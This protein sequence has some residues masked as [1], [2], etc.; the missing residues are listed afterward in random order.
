[1]RETAV[2]L[3]KPLG[4]H[5]N[6]AIALA[7]LVCFSAVVVFAAFAFADTKENEAAELLKKADDL[8]NKEE[9]KQSWDIYK[10]LLKDY[11]GTTAVKRAQG[12]IKKKI[13]TC[14]DK[15]GVVTDISKLFKGKAVLTKPSGADYLSLS[16]DFSDKE[17]LKDFKISAR[18]QSSVSV[19]DKKLQINCRKNNSIILPLKDTIFTRQLT[20]E[21]DFDVVSAAAEDWNVVG[22]A[23]FDDNNSTG[24]FFF[25]HY[26]LFQSG[27]YGN[28]IGL[29]AEKGGLSGLKIIS[30]QAKPVIEVGKPQH[31]KIESKDGYHTLTINGQASKT[32]NDN[33][34]TLGVIGIGCSDATV[35][36]SNLKIAGIL[37]PQWVKKTLSGQASVALAVDE[38]KQGLEDSLKARNEKC[39]QINTKDRNLLEP[40]P[41]EARKAYQNGVMLIDAYSRINKAAAAEIFKEFNRALECAPKFAL[42]YYYRAVCNYLL[43]N[44][45]AA[46][47][48]LSKAVE[49]SPDFYEAYKKRADI[50]VDMSKF[51]DA[52]KDYE[53]ALSIKNDYPY[54]LAGLGYLYFILGEEKKSTDCLSKALSL[55]PENPEAIEYN[56]FL[57][58]IIKGPPWKQTFTKSS[59]HYIVKTDTS[60]KKADTYADR[61]EKAYR[62][63]QSFFPVKEDSKQKKGTV[64][65]FDSQTSY[66]TYAFLTTESS[67][68]NTLGYYHPHYRQLLLFEPANQERET[69]GVLYHEAFHMFLHHQMG[70]GGKLPI[71]LNE[72]MAEF[73]RGTDFEQGTQVGLVLKDRLSELLDYIGSRGHY[74]F[75]DIMSQ[76]KREFYEEN[77]SVKYAQAW[78]MVHFFQKYKNGTYA[79]VLKAY[80]NSLVAGESIESVFQKTFAKQDLNQMEREWVDYVK[81]LKP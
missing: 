71:W 6:R 52:L 50:L 29:L 56:K 48:D 44:R 23:F 11:D 68:A 80:F 26:K 64:L 4:N 33:S 40:F 49:N 47:D 36:F 41:E 32:A 18:E 55:D 9:W 24:Y 27:A 2:T 7:M 21:Y 57:R 70:I 76:T 31:I 53:K 45:T 42:A 3:A 19:K 16:Y 22:I 34:I 75:E 58:Q 46:I 17:Q 81:N 65:L 66:K 43:E 77:P 59:S 28:L 63:Y 51:D 37:D 8:F 38:L 62:I 15:M 20:I 67:V 39:E 69:M 1:M 54:G 35:T 5:K 25:L 73:F 79:G 13:K 12:E 78:S 14:E 72:G 60:Q 10:K 30:S 74:G 61:L